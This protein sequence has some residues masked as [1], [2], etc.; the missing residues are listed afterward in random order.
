MIPRGMIMFSAKVS[1]FKSSYKYCTSLL[2]TE[3][4]LIVLLYPEWVISRH[5]VNR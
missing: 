1:K 2:G 5:T 4:Y 3:I